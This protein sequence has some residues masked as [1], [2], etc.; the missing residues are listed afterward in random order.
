MTFSVFWEVW[1]LWDFH[2][3]WPQSGLS[4]LDGKY[5]TSL[6]CP[7]T[8]ASILL[9]LD[10][11]CTFP[12]NAS[13]Q[14]SQHEISM[15]QVQNKQTI[16]LHTGNSQVLELLAT[17]C[18]KCWNAEQVKKE[19]EKLMQEEKK[20]GPS[21]HGDTTFITDPDLRMVGAWEN[22]AIFLPWCCTLA[23]ASSVNLSETSCGW[24]FDLVLGL[25]YLFLKHFIFKA[26]QNLK[27][28][29]K[30]QAKSLN[31]FF[32]NKSVS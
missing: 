1:Q 12:V 8:V 14:E 22:I 2:L 20:S 15:W 16:I 6:I 3:L 11:E 25:L 13:R 21:K 29:H 27:S 9:L 28:K 26:A 10:T 4:C 30:F 31:V 23:E 18:C 19:S 7:D 5:I 17:G 32:S 24:T